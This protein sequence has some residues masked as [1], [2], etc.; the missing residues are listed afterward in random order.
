MRSWV[1]I[2]AKM[3][4]FSDN[5]GIAPED[6]SLRDELQS[7]AMGACSHHFRW[8]ALFPQVRS[9]G[10]VVDVHGE[11]Y[12]HAEALLQFGDWRV[13]NGEKTFFDIEKWEK[14]IEDTPI[15]ATWGRDATAKI[16]EFVFSATSGDHADGRQIMVYQDSVKLTS[17]PKTKSAGKS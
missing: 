9:D 6:F 11:A 2:Y 3:A 15:Y 4:A 8:R 14:V 5:D 7:R 17:G 12:N 16:L 10:T 13:E 1:D